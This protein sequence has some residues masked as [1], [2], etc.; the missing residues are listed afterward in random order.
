MSTLIGQPYGWGGMY[1]YSDCSAELKSIFTLFGIYLLR[2]SSEQ[3]TI[4]KMVNQSTASPEQKLSYLME[5]GKSILTLVYIGDHIIMY[6][7]DV[8]NRNKTGTSIM[9]TYQNLWGGT[10]SQPV[11]RA[12][13]G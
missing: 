8:L 1:F 3:V 2:H 5:Q 9:M 10:L 12:V 7:G 6:V 11:R 4:D 13:M